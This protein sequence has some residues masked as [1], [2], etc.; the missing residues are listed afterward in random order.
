MQMLFLHT[1][2][3]LNPGV[4]QPGDLQMIVYICSSIWVHSNNY[5]IHEEHSTFWHWGPTKTK[6]IILNCVINKFHLS[7]WGGSYTAH[8]IN[9]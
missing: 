3:H 7:F 5:Y 8:N 6:C 2:K 4:G 1:G 9:K